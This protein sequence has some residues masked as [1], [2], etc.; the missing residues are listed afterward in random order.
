MVAAVNWPLLL[1]LGLFIVGLLPVALLV[2]PKM[3]RGDF[4]SMRLEPT[5]QSWVWGPIL[6]HAWVRS[7]F[8]ATWFGFVCLV[9]LPLAFL[10]SGPAWYGA[11]VLVMFFGLVLLCISVV[12]FNHPRICIPLPLRDAPGLLNEL[13]AKWSNHGTG[14]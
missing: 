4:W 6:W 13:R 9:A 8:V 7:W 14:S 2:W 11:L 1:G 5:P 10:T 12:L 3:W